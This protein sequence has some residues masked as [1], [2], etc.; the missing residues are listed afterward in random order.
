MQILGANVIP[1]DRGTKTMKDAV[2]AAFEAYVK[3]P[4]TQPGNS[5]STLFCFNYPRLFF[6]A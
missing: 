1:V 6:V 4:V 2:D 5:R 3:D